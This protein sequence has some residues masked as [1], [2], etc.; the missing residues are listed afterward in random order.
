MYSSPVEK[1]I[2]LREESR[3]LHTELIIRFVLKLVEILKLVTWVLLSRWVSRTLNLM[4]NAAT[5]HT[6]NLQTLSSFCCFAWS[7]RTKKTSLVYFKGCLFNRINIMI[8]YDFTRYEPLF[9]YISR[10]VQKMWKKQKSD[11]LSYNLMLIKCF[12][13]LKCIIFFI[14]SDLEK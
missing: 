5:G 2:V 9:I 7:F 10:E 12:S 14:T 8:I 13:S 6:L 3:P 11:T 4:F 1:V